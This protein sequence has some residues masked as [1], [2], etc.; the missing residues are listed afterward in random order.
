MKKI[1]LMSLSA[2]IIGIIYLFFFSDF[3]NIDGCLDSGGCWDYQDKVCRKE[4]S[5]AQQ[6]C[7]RANP[8][9]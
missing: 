4:E 2:F 9:R 6:L 1:L 5:N 3:M 8:Y 7:D